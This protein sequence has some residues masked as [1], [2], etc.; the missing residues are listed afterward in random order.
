MIGR[1]ILE[2][3]DNA[4]DLPEGFIGSRNLSRRMFLMRNL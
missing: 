2:D 1:L 3:K 4:K